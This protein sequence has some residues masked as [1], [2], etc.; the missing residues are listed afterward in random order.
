MSRTTEEPIDLS[1]FIEAEKIK[2]TESLKA[3]V[4]AYQKRMLDHL[5]WKH[6]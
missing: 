6:A 4:E 3:S 1:D 5:G 2:S